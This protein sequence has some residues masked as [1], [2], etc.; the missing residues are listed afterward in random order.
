MAI[1]IDT[2]SNIDIS[3]I[4]HHVKTISRSL[5][6]NDHIATL[7]AVDQGID[8]QLEIFQSLMKLQKE[9]NMKDKASTIRSLMGGLKDFSNGMNDGDKELMSPE[10]SKM[11]DTIPS[12]DDF[13][14]DMATDKQLVE[15][16]THVLGFQDL[17][18]MIEHTEGMKELSR[19]L[20]DIYQDVPLS[21]RHLRQLKDDPYEFVNYE[22]SPFE[23]GGKGK[24]QSG[25]G[26]FHPSFKN[27][28][29][30]VKFRDIMK[31]ARD[32]ARQRRVTH[33]YRQRGNRHSQ[34]KNR[35]LQVVGERHQNRTNA[36]PQCFPTC[37]VANNTCNCELLFECTGRMSSYDITVLMTSEYIDDDGTYTSG[38][39]FINV[40]DATGEA[41]LSKLTRAKANALDANP[42]NE[43]Q[44]MNVLEEFHSTCNPNVQGEVC[45]GGSVEYQSA[46]QLSVD[47][48]CTSVDTN[49]KL[50]F[51]SIYDT[52]DNSTSCGLNRAQTVHLG[53]DTTYLSIEARQAQCF[54]QTGCS[55]AD[56]SGVGDCE[57]GCTS[58]NKCFAGQGDW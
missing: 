48:V 36:L 10:L 7:A 43:N 45:P 1:D 6:G 47:Q 58:N 51:E 30:N 38:D 3:S 13:E 24:F 2:N 37:D 46:F 34:E 52:F 12:L 57:A 56:C 44:C 33:S 20:T 16:F 8:N 5:R 31:K 21:P 25:Q 9:G 14:M 35:R 54:G 40:F 4:S 53:C 18:R 19:T 29:N 23:F 28:G 39:D 41:I 55:D 27:F 11:M 42:T 26:H 32:D 50:L 17:D 15:M 22:G 49:T